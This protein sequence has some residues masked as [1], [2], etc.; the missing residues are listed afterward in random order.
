M[1]F[2]WNSISFKVLVV[3]FFFIGGYFLYN[4]YSNSYERKYVELKSSIDKY[5]AS[6][7]TDL[8]ILKNERQTIITLCDSYITDFPTSKF[9]SIISDFIL[10]KSFDYKIS[11]Y[12]KNKINYFLSNAQYDCLNQSVNLV[13]FEDSLVNSIDTLLKQK[14][15]LVNFLDKNDFDLYTLSARLLEKRA[16]CIFPRKWNEKKIVLFSNMQNLAKLHV[17]NLLG[18]I[19]EQPSNPLSVIP[20]SLN[21]QDSL[22]ISYGFK[23]I[24]RVVFNQVYR[25]EVSCYE[26]GFFGI[27][28]G[29]KKQYHMVKLSGELSG[30]IKSLGE[31]DIISAVD[32]KSIQ[33]VEKI[34]I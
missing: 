19:Q 29:L 2:Q 34:L 31:F 21:K 15:S 5:H 24:R 33:L 13:L 20:I 18:P 6:N 27:F 14:D 3:I 25:V 22:V 17:Y 30:E 1:K 32:M 26:E 4:Y 28:K 7:Y 23:Q 10:K 16:N 11:D 12:L 8:Y 9:T